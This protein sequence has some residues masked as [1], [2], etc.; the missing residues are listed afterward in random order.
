MTV[1]F[2]PLIEYKIRN[3]FM[4]KSCRK[5]GPMASPRP[6]SILVNNPKEPFHAKSSFKTQIF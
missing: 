4:E 5:F 1:K 3:I 6:L 2:C